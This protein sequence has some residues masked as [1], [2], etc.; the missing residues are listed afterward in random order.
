MP[1][2]ARVNPGQRYYTPDAA[3]RP[4]PEPDPAARPRKIWAG[5]PSAPS[6]G[7]LRRLLQQCSRATTAVQ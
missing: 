6:A 4:V 5:G 2:R 7:L 1:R 3:P